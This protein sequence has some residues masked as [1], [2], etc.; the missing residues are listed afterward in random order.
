[1]EAAAPARTRGGAASGASGCSL[2]SVAAVPAALHQ[3]R[4][5]DAAAT[6][7]HAPSLIGGLD[8]GGGHARVLRPHAAHVPLRANPRGLSQAGGHRLQP[9]AH[10]AP[11][12]VRHRAVLARCPCCAR[13]LP[14][15]AAVHASR[16]TNHRYRSPHTRSGLA[17]GP[18]RRAPPLGCRCRGEAAVPAAPIRC[19]I[20]VADSLSSRV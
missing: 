2:A 3:L 7:R 10:R 20:K 11:G 6:Q 13:A 18:K 19:A 17:A 1:M 8:G 9:E 15:R 16:P 12:M 4:S 14:V 5:G